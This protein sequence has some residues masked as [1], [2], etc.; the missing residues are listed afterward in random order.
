MDLFELIPHINTSENAIQFLR[1]REILRSVPPRCPLAACQREMS[2]V[3]IG[4][5]R[6]SGGAE[7]MWRCPTHKSKKYPLGMVSLYMD[8]ISYLHNLGSFLQNS[9]LSPKTFVLFTYLWAHGIPNHV[10]QSLCGLGHTSV[11]DWNMF[12]R[13]ICSRQLLVNPIQLDGPNCVV[14]IGIFGSILFF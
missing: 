2:E 13:D 12:L 3:S 6:A 9:N 11:T 8:F 5:R 1:D 14:Q 7:K 4:R 10:Q